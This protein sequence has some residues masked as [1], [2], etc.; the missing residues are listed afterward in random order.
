[1]VMKKRYLRLF[2]LGLSI[3]LIL[4]LNFSTGTAKDIKSLTLKD[5][6]VNAVLSF[7]AD[8]GNVNIVASPEVEG[9]ISLTLHQVSWREALNILL[10]TYGLAGVEEKG[11]IRV[12]PLNQYMQ[13]VMVQE[14]HKTEQEALV[15]LNTEVVKIQNATASELIKPVK[16]VLSSRGVI[17]VDE[18]TNSLIIRDIPA[19][20][21][22]AKDMIT[23][24]DKE[25]DQIEITAQ[26]LE[27][28]SSALKEL[29]IDW[30]FFTSRYGPENSNGGYKTSHEATIEQMGDRVTDP[31]GRFTYST[32][33]EDFDLSGTVSAL[34][35]EKKA[36]LI[37]SP[38]ITTMDNRIALIQM[39]QK[40]PIKQFD[41]AGNVVTTFVEVGTILRVTPHK[42][43]ENRILM[44]LR[45]E[46]SSYQFDPNG[47]IINTNNAE[48]N[49]VVDNGQP[50]VI[51]G[52]TSQEKKTTKTGLPILKD[53]PLIGYLFSHTQDEIV[54]RELIITVT[55]RIVAAGI[56]GGLGS[57]FGTEENK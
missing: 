12:L 53:L 37:A 52:L 33:Q 51:G 1:M 7:L 28:E 6:D 18:R 13:E 43:S 29:G 27:I 48:T 20:I 4:S 35:N 25:T 49:V 56:K 39:G 55:P 5:A 9:E 24:L 54:N 19:N 15:S 14:K 22:R 38:V 41:A 45:P 50:A 42:T 32:V 11:Y 23:T 31:I 47:V 34:M 16:T 2:L 40:I 46:R 30:T 10:K 21:A 57:T 17:D 26:L 3:F 44:N 36:K 8:Y